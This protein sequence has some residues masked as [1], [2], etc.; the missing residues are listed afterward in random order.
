MQR[1]RRLELR[2]KIF[3]R[4]EI[5]DQHLTQGCVQETNR[6][7]N[8]SDRNCSLRILRESTA[9]FSRS[10]LDPPHDKVVALLRRNERIRRAHDDLQDYHVSPSV[11]WPSVLG[12]V[13]GLPTLLYQFLRQGDVNALADLLISRSKKQK[14]IGGADDKQGNS[15]KMRSLSPAPQRPRFPRK[16]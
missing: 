4:E 1:C 10:R 7:S 14:Q 9:L 2:P 8:C 15:K 5:E 11:L 3:F 12:R 16:L 6:G 13:S